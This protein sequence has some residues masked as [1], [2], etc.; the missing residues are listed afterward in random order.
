MTGD[1]NVKPG[2]VP[3]GEC[4]QRNSF[5]YNTPGKHPTTTTIP[6]PPRSS[7]PPLRLSPLPFGF[8]TVEKQFGS[9]WKI[10]DR[11]PR[12]LHS[13]HR[14]LARRLVCPIDLL[15]WLYVLVL[16]RS[17]P[18]K[19]C[20]C[21]GPGTWTTIPTWPFRMQAG[22]RPVTLK[23]FHHFAKWVK[24]PVWMPSSPQCVLMKYSDSSSHRTSM[25]RSTP[26]RHTMPPVTNRRSGLPPVMKWQ[27]TPGQCPASLPV[28]LRKHLMVNI[29]ANIQPVQA[30]TH[31]DRW[32][33]TYPWD[34]G[35][36]P[37]EALA[38]FFHPYET[39]NPCQIGKDTLTIEW[40]A[41]APTR[42]HKN[43][44]R[45]SQVRFRERWGTDETWSLIQPQ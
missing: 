44:V 31:P 37:R 25:K 5:R 20:L 12:T 22:H 15:S 29:P 3:Q 35:I 43:I 21:H 23:R 2:K 17:S 26:P 27:P 19:P 10:V 40:P 6:L 39:F 41:R 34:L 11:D 9:T 32:A 18:I 42:L 28:S 38:R 1:V 4:S 36:M 33:I 16:P 14:E 8:S 45:A 7:L 30:S 24:T 13:W